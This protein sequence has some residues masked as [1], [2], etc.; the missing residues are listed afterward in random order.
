MEI[1]FGAIFDDCNFSLESTKK[2]FRERIA[3]FLAK[4]CRGSNGFDPHPKAMLTRWMQK[5]GCQFWN[6]SA[7]GPKLNQGVGK[8]FQSSQSA[9]IKRLTLCYSHLSRQRN[10]SRMCLHTACHYPLRVPCCI[11]TTKGRKLH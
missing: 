8:L 10:S 6:L 5:K 11:E 2:I 9:Q 1:L 4:Y 3:P 7:E